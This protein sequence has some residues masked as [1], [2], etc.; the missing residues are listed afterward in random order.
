MVQMLV[1][2]IIIIKA[3]SL[4]M[5]HFSWLALTN[6]WQSNTSVMIILHPDF[7]N[8]IFCKLHSLDEN[9]I[10]IKILDNF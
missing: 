5:M 10:C 1:Y 7:M 8:I 9:W 2:E 3:P 4:V 6:Y